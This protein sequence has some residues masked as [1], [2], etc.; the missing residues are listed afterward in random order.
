MSMPSADE[1]ARRVA[2]LLS[3]YYAPGG[4][5]GDG[6]PAAASGGSTPRAGAAAARG[7]TTNG[8]SSSSAVNAS[9]RLRTS[10]TSSA[11]NQLLDNDDGSF[12]ADA[13]LASLLQRA[14]L[15]EL[16]ATHARLTSEA[17]VSGGGGVEWGCGGSNAEPAH[18]RIST[19]PRGTRRR[20][21]S[22]PRPAP[23]FSHC[24][25][26]AAVPFKG[27]RRRRRACWTS[28]TT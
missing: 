25:A 21:T 2:S 27:P 10:T 28:A 15:S 4:A 9:A 19:L 13:W 7:G 24:H 22:A 11:A 3:S 6:G 17:K 8:Q 20:P 1:K 23:T 18:A 12:D 26:S 16:L 5:S 14:P